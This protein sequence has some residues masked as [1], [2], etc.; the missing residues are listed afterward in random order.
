MASSVIPAVKA[1]LLAGL[2]GDSYTPLSGVRVA[3]GVPIESIPPNGEMVVLGNAEAPQEARALGRLKRRESVNL[4][5]YVDVHRS[6]T[7]QAALTTRAFVIAEAIED[8]LRADP[9]LT[10]DYAGDGEIVAAQF[11]GVERLEEFAGDRTRRA[12]LTCTVSIEA[13]I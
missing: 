13:R 5:V 6:T 7:D 1:A 10:A 2:D 4:T 8:Y 12:L 3:W 11:M 9:S